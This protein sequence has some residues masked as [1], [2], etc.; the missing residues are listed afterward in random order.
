MNRKQENLYVPNYILNKRNQSIDKLLEEF[1]IL[2][3]HM[4]YLAIVR[5]MDHICG[6]FIKCLPNQARK[7]FCQDVI[8]HIPRSLCT[9]TR[10]P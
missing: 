10:S 5:A 2:Q 7:I 4:W 6:R 3:Y 1:R 8:S 9:K